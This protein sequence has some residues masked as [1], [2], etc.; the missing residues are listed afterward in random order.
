MLTVRKKTGLTEQLYFERQFSQAGGWEKILFLYSVMH[1]SFIVPSR[2]RT[3]KCR[4]S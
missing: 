1:T 3:V 2:N 4:L